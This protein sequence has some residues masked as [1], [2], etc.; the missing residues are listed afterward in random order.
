MSEPSE[1]VEPLAPPADADD[2]GYSSV[3]KYLLYTLSLPE[4]TL[5][6]GAGLVGGAVR[7]SAALLVP[8]AFQNSK[9]Y[10]TMVRQMLDFL[11]EDVGGVAKRTDDPAAPPAV[12]NF[13]ARKTVGNFI[14]LAGLATLHLSPLTL[15]AVVSDVAYGSQT[16]LKELAEELK[17]EGVIERDSTID[18]VD[19]L[20]AAVAKTSGTL[21][22]A[23][24]TPPLSVEGL[25]RTIDQTRAAATTIDLTSVVPQAEMQRMWTEIHDLA[26]R[27]GVGVLDVSTAMTLSA[28]DKIGDVGRGALSGVRVA[29][30]LFDRHV[31]EHYEQAL[32]RVRTR[33]YYATLAEASGPYIEAVWTNFSTDRGTITEGLFSGKYLGQAWSAARRWLGGDR[34]EPTAPLP[35]E[36]RP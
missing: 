14:E 11:V 19:D 5:R 2:P 33:G 32:E 18:H 9:T 35:S 22:S 36:P 30:T 13:V 17:K 15:L 6:S 20:L 4:R 8:Q 29:G 10:S 24:D 28:L 34:G 12:E 26:R 27:D 1:R 7:E 3:R 31:I 23:F 21:A 16:Y 25:K